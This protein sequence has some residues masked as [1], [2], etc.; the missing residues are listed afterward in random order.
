M[1]KSQ[2]LSLYPKV[3]P[4]VKTGEGAVLRATLL[5]FLCC[6]P[7]F[8]LNQSVYWLHTLQQAFDNQGPDE[9]ADD[10][11]TRNRCSTAGELPSVMYSH[12]NRLLHILP[13]SRASQ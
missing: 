1:P 12:A 6:I 3:D 2:H 7:C 10:Y 8:R 9:A 4:F 11:K 5:L 13:F